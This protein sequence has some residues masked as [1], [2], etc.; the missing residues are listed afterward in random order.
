MTD[1]RHPT[2]HVTL[3]LAALEQ[4]DPMAPLLFPNRRSWCPLPTCAASANIRGRSLSLDVTQGLWRCHRCGAS[5]QLVEWR[6]RTTDARGP[7]G[8]MPRGGTGN[9]SLR[10][11]S[12][13]FDLAQSVPLLGT[14]GEVYLAQRGISLQ[15]AMKAGVRRAVATLRVS[16]ARGQMCASTNV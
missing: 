15:V 7:G 1:R 6:G 10:R 11:T 13:E 4:F 2:V 5:G 9:Q 12:W 8:A 16:A 14:P 3:S